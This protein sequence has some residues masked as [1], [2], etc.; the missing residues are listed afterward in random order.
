MLSTPT[1][2]PAKNRNICLSETAYQHKGTRNKCKK[3]NQAAIIQW[4]RQCLMDKPHRKPWPKSKR[5]NISKQ[6]P[7]PLHHTFLLGCARFTAQPLSALLTPIATDIADKRST[8]RIPYKPEF[9]SG[10]LFATAKVAYTTAMIRPSLISSLRSSHI[11]F[12]Y[13]RNFNKLLVKTKLNSRI[14][15]LSLT[16]LACHP[17]KNRKS[18]SRWLLNFPHP[19]PVFNSHPKYSPRKIAKSR[20][21]PNLLWTLIHTSEQ[22]LKNLGS[23]F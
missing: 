4:Q 8:V 1:K 18:R 23:H 12:P 17:H 22:Q 10:F 21:P 9:F 20:I 6:S 16:I 13:I 7:S 11:W 19:A 14:P 3:T 2:P 15:L 5:S